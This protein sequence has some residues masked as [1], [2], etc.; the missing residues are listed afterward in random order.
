MREYFALRARQGFNYVHSEVIGLVRASNLDAA[1][2]EQP[3][4]H[5]YRAES[6]NPAYFDTVNARL[7]QANGLGITVGLILMEPY[8]TPASSIDPAFRYDNR[9]WMSFP[10]EAARLRYARY[11]VARYSASNVLFLLTLEWGPAGK[12]LPLEERVA[13]FNRIGD[14]VRKSDPHGRLRGIHDAN[15][16]LPDHFYGEAS[17][18]NTLGQYCQYSGSDYGWPWCDGCTP[19][20]DA[21]CR[22]RFATPTNRH[23]LHDEMKQV[24]V[25]RGRNRPVING[26]YAYYL[27]RSVPGHPDVVNRGHSHDRPT[28][29]KAAWVLTMS[30]CYIVPGFWRTYYGGWAG[31]GTKF[32]PDDPEARPAVNDLQTLRAFFTQSEGGSRREW[33]RLEPHDELV[34]VADPNPAA[35]AGPGYAYCLADPGRGYVVY[36][37]N[38]R[39]ARLTLRGPPGATYRVMR[40]DPRTGERTTLMPS[41]KGATSL[42]LASPDVDDWAFEVV[43]N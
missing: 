13:M 5:D 43:K 21:N 24:R 16:N 38:A 32:Q 26:E 18:W 36:F 9:C 14:E 34:S 19:P 3:A 23:T 30:G 10:D 40:F 35:G 17:A 39:S 37:E 12:P 31:R 42:V 2:R 33:W 1:G 22:G 29:R 25:A 4:F 27:R 11:I 20:N 8:F 15:G 7:S 41:A 28:F 6:L